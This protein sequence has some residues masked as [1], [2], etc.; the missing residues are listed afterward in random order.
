[1]A[2]ATAAPDTFTATVARHRQFKECPPVY[3]NSGC[4]FLI[5]VSNGGETVVQ[6]P[7]QGP[8]EGSD[9][10]LIGVVNNS[11][12]PIYELP[13]SVPSSD[14]FGFDGDGICDPGATPFPSGMRS[15]IPVRRPGT[16]ATEARDE[17]CAFP[18]PTRH[19]R[20]ATGVRAERLRGPDQLVLEH[21]AR[22]ELGS[23][24]FL[25]AD[26]AGPVDLLQS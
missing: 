19:E 16:S 10:S 25:A 18:P 24:P 2:V 20:R 8:Y 15:V 22:H 3:E 6:D 26:P 5:T 23:G 12:S 14:L 11:S 13:L 4:Q 1:M 7:N 17:G 9:D 21:L